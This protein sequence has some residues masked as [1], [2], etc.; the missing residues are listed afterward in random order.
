MKIAIIG[1]GLAGLACAIE[2]ER[3][4]I[5]P[6]VFERDES[7]GW[8]WPCTVHWLNVLQRQMGDIR[9]SLREKYRLDLKPINELRTLKM[10]SP[11]KET[12]IEGKLGNI[13]TRGKHRESVENQLFT[14]LKKTPVYFN[15]AADYKELSKKY[16]Y[17][18][19]ATGKDT[20]A[21]EMGL[22][23]DYGVVHLRGGLVFGTFESTSSTVYFN[24]RY[25]GQGYA[26]LA[27]WSSTQAIIGLC[28]IGCSEYEM[29][30]LYTNF[31]EEE[32]LAHLEFYYKFSLPIFSTGRVSNFK[33]GNVLLVGR[34]AG[35][36]ERLLGTGA[37]EALI[38]GILAARAMIQDLDYES[39]VRPLQK[40]VENI[41]AIRAPYENLDN[42]GLDRLVAM[43]NTPGIKQA[44]YNT[45][46]NFIDMAGGILNKIKS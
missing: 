37:V 22:W 7:V 17:V 33:S 44:I 42:E 23:I 29:D 16:D 45:G 34:S 11:N 25:A 31:L 4:G 39:L 2:C 12:S 43:I 19:V 32:N 40:H 46:I 27:P 36:T 10:K 3:L 20:A 5:I 38:S 28:N 30:R 18:V 15:R 6:D 1:A 13:M 35:L 26:R 14:L 21:K 9:E 8:P 41:S 24:T